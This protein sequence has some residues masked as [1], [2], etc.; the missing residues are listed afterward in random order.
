MWTPF[1]QYIT[2]DDVRYVFVKLIVKHSKDWQSVTSI[3][4]IGLHSHASVVGLVPVKLIA[5]ILLL[6]QSI[7]LMLGLFVKSSS[8]ILLYRQS[9]YVR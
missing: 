2:H 9:R 1:P 4:V 7:F 6:E 5:W 8:L 3:Y